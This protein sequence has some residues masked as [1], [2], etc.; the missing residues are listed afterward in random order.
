MVGSRERKTIA[1]ALDLIEIL[2]FWHNHCCDIIGL[3][4]I[5]WRHFE[6]GL[7][8]T[9]NL[10]ARLSSLSSFLIDLSSTTGYQ[11]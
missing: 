6:T 8:G 3:P 2:S 11:P 4:F 1:L 9:P 5:H 10:S 7:L